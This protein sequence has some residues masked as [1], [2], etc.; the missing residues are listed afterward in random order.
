MS[1]HLKMQTDAK[2]LIYDFERRF[3]TLHQAADCCTDMT[4]T[5]SVFEAIDP[6][7]R[8]I[9]TWAGGFLDTTYERIHGKWVAS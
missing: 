2:Q 7:V 9:Q 6:D 3:G 5:I 1:H 4:G 8:K